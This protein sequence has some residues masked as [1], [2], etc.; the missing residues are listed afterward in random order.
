[1]RGRFGRPDPFSHQPDRHGAGQEPSPLRV[2]AAPPLPRAASGTRRGL[3]PQNR[4]R[5]SGMKSD[6]AMQVVRSTTNNR[7]PLVAPST[8]ISWA[9]GMPSFIAA[10]ISVARS[11]E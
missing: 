8:G 7:I 10:P 6:P 2:S 3:L 5:P 11:E 9:M 4:Q 1:D